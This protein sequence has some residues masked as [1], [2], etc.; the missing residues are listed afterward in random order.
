MK[1][2]DTIDN[3]GKISITEWNN[4]RCTR[5]YK[6]EVEKCERKTER[7]RRVFQWIAAAH[8]DGD[9][10]AFITWE[11]I[12]SRFGQKW[13]DANECYMPATAPEDTAPALTTLF[14]S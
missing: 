10:A 14:E 9:G 8:D 6:A 13:H 5:I 4:F 2:W 11:D 12:K 3:D 1:N 7:D